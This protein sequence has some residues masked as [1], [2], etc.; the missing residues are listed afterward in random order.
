[1][2]RRVQRLPWT[3]CG[4]YSGALTD[5]EVRYLYGFVGHWKFAEGSGTTAADSSGLANT[6]TLSGGATW[7]TTCAGINALTTNGT[8]GI[9]QTNAPFTP[10][11]VGTVAFWM[12]G[13][14]DP[15]TTASNHGIG[16]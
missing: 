14:G 6:A 7:E 9:A 4:V 2:V 16:R 1:M 15:S 13:A 11:S 3:T 12:R 5:A 10:P 8:G